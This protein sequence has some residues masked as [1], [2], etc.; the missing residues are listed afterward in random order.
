MVTLVLVSLCAVCASPLSVSAAQGGSANAQPSAAITGVPY[1]TGAPAVCA[2]SANSLDLFVKGTSITTGGE[3]GTFSADGALWWRHWDGAVWYGWT[4]L[5]GILTSDPVAVSQG[6]GKVDVFVRGADGALWQKEYN[7][8]AWGGWTSLGGIIYPGTG[9]AVS[10]SAGRLDVFVEGM[11][12]ALWHQGNNGAWSGW[13]SLGGVLTSSPVATSST[14]GKIDV[15]V[16]GAD[17]GLWETTYSGGLS[18]GSTS[19]YYVPQAGSTWVNHGTAGASYNAYVSTPSLFQTQA[20]G[21]P[22]WGDIGK[23]DFICIPAGSATNNPNVASWEIGFRFSG[24]ASDASATS[25]HRYQK[26]WDKAYGG[27]GF[28]I[29]TEYGLTN[30]NNNYLTIYRATTSGSPKARW[31]IPTDTPLHVGHNYYIQISWDTSA[32][33]GKEPYP[34]VWIGEDGNAPVHQTHWDES[35]G[36]LS[37]TG[38]WYDDSVGTATLGSTSSGLACGSSASTNTDWLIGGFFVY[39][40]YNSIVDFSSGGSWST[41]KLAWT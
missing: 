26:I 13:E 18:P 23:N 36:A 7:N 8:N 25:A 9:P 28:K 3:A 29:D 4:S 21:Y 20:N 31:Y 41:D 35:G 24:I 19:I 27:F 34:T 17:S 6:A 15:F 32:G 16:R 33:P 12:L 2:P 11:N 22:Y 1:F 10:S 39:R 14:S 38:S 5:G 30:G 37:G 40:Q